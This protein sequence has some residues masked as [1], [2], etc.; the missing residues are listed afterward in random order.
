MNR[1]T[2]RNAWL[3]SII[4]L[5]AVFASC[6]K[7]TVGDS[8][9]GFPY[10]DAMDASND[11][12]ADSM[13]DDGATQDD[14]QTDAGSGGDQDAGID[15]GI[16]AGTDAGTDDGTDAGGDAGG[17][18]DQ[19]VNFSFLIYGDSRSGGGCSGNEVHISLVQRM[20]QEQGISFVVNV[21]DMVSGYDDSTC[22]ADNGS[23]TGESDYGDLGRIIQPLSSRTPMPGLPVYYFPVIGNHEE[24]S[25]WYPDP[26][27]GR[28]CDTFDMAS[29][30]NHP[31]PNSDP[32]G[33]DYPY[34][35][36]YS[37]SYGHVAF[38]VLRANSDYFD[39]FECNYP[40]DGWDS[41]E[42]YC[43]NGPRNDQ[44]YETCWNV[45]QYDWLKNGLEQADADPS[46][47]RKIIILHAPIYTSF[48]DHTPFTSAMDVA[49]LAD[50]HHVSLVFNGHNHCYER[51]YPI[52]AGSQDPTGTTYITTSGGGVGTYDASG[53][54]FTAAHSGEHHYTRIDINENSITGQ[55]IA[56]DGSIIDSF[57]L[58]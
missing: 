42:D 49:A 51:T 44:L 46:I 24:G 1:A 6:Q 5:A 41:C 18:E 29:I 21:G 3:F 22:F 53:D 50:E 30:V 4:L 52:R 17:D 33:D 8:D 15:A 38:F 12:G 37:F 10:Q 47:T 31:T 9:S 55:A 36:Y 26:C 34:F 28:I 43:K 13:S 58:P 35:D 45:H 19:P 16:D 39:F 48:E 14:M 32:C 56:D 2:K 54:W 11:S 20:V 23:C 25:D 40:P 57:T 27:G 7:G